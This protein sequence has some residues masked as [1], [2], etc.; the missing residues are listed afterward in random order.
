MLWQFPTTF[1][2]A[3]RLSIAF[4]L[5]VAIVAVAYLSIQ[6]I[7]VQRFASFI[8]ESS[9]KGQTNDIAEAI[10]VDP[11]DGTV[12]GIDDNGYLLL[13]RQDGV[14]QAFASGEVSFQPPRP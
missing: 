7:L 2:L 11:I 12:A 13:K 4:A 3:L 9:L 10:E 14:I 1:S 6:T 5:S 8:T